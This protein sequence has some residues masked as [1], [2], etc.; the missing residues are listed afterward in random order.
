MNDREPYAFAIGDVKLKYGLMLAPLAGVSDHPFRRVCRACGAEYTVSEMV[1]AK[2]L[3]YEKRSR[4]VSVGERSKT[5]PL[6]AV[7]EDDVPMAVQLFGSDPDFM[8]QAAALIEEG[9]YAGCISRAK[10]AAIDINMG[11]PVHK[12]VSNGEGSALLRDIPL[13]G[14]I[15]RAVRAAVSLPVTVKIRIGFDAES[16]CAVEMARELEASG[17]S[18]V[19][20]HGRTREQMYAPGVNLEAIAAVKQSVRIP[21]IGNGDIYT[22]EDAL[23]MK[24][25]TGCD[26]WMIAR[27]AMG[28]PWLFSDIIAAMNGE[29][30]R[31]ITLEERVETALS[32]LDQMLEEKGERVG[33]AEGKK[34]M[35]WYIHGVA[36]AAQ[37]RGQIMNAT[38]PEEI[39]IVLRG[40]L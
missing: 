26:G 4:R 5:A 31:E 11:C 39:K 27:G 14:R 21:V 8:A 19:C 1:S 24:R 30:P 12:I 18:A 15:V 38:T 37:A 22:A 13:A 33:L 40:L 6:A 16:V 28:N 10:P 32:Q 2:A 23:R 9:S 25:E 17:A 7:H 3:C 35:A 36:G 34:Q 20:V 29:D